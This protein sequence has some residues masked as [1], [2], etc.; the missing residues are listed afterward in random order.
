[1][2]V[3]NTGPAHEIIELDHGRLDLYHQF[4]SP[5]IAEHLFQQ[6][7]A[8]L[9]WQQAR[10]RLQGKEIPIPRL[11]AWYGDPD[12]AY[13]YSGIALAPL[14]WNPE[15]QALREQLNERF[16]QVFH[17]HFNSVLCNLYRDGQD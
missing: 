3:V 9:Q 13:G 5:D 10:I 4:L 16:G 6:L 14:P 2:A 12:T 8:G 11:Q 15:L 7:Q 1:E 17:T